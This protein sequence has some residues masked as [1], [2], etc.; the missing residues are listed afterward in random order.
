MFSTDNTEGLRNLV[1]VVS[2]K[3]YLLESLMKSYF[4]QIFVSHFP[5]L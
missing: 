3:V 5:Q 4:P 1:K 2:L